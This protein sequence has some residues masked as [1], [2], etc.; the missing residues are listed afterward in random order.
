MTVAEGITPDPVSKP[1]ALASRL[2][3]AVLPIRDDGSK[4]P[5]GRLGVYDATTD[6]QRIVDLW[7]DHPGSLV[8]V[9]CGASGLLVVDIDRH[10]GGADGFAS[11]DAAAVDLPE[12]WQHASL[13]GKGSHLVYAAPEGAAGGSSLAGVDLKGAGGYIVWTGDVPASR[14]LFAPAPQWTLRPARENAAPTPARVAEWITEHVGEPD[15]KLADA[16]AALPA[17]GAPEWSNENLVPLALP[18]VQAARW[19]H[20]GAQARERFV[21]RYAAGQWAD[22]AHRRDAARAF[23]HA[24]AEIGYPAAFAAIP[25][26]EVSAE[27]LRAFG[28]DAAISAE[29]ITT[30]AP[31]PFKILTRADLKALPRPDWLIEGLVQESGIVVLAGEGGLGKSFLAI[32]WAC[33]LATGENWF[34]R[35]V[36]RGRVL[37]VA[38]E[39]VE[40]FDDR[41]TAWEEYNSLRVPDERLQYVRE[42]FTL[43][44]P[45]SVEYMRQAVTERAYDLVILDTL[46]QL[47]EVENENDN[48]QLAAIMRQARA[49][50]QARP[51]CSVLIVHHTN[52]GERGKVRG[53][54]AIRSNADAVIVARAS[55]GDTFKLST[56]LEHDGKQKNGV[57]EVLPG[58]HL[59]DAGL[60]AVVERQ[61]AADPDAQAIE[62]V[63]AN[64]GEHA[65]SEFLIAR[66]ENDPATAKRIKR[67]LGD[68]AEAG[69]VVVTGS[70]SARR[71]QALGHD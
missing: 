28:F 3:L 20:G 4:R 58:F 35:K 10:E 1:L 67:K 33:R 52:K 71:W 13:S 12:T 44:D 69:R 2:G 11:L 55:E 21:E 30:A 65:I 47:A 19:S 49:I 48:A 37:Y 14:D 29:S 25:N 32:D 36:K 24:L 57:A 61:G 56:K 53:A 9:A 66:G 70:T 68:L 8:G 60:S 16:L 51:G 17:H 22:D 39:G 43:S 38:G 59:L 18:L 40:F 34:G 50:R 62:Q 42:G 26:I 5:A 23:D 46:S 27:T 31:A 63:L 64:P 15:A 6:P 54:S 7:T 41:L 45:A